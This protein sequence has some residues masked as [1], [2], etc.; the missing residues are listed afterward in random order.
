MRVWRD[1]AAFPLPFLVHIVSHSYVL[2]LVR[3]VDGSKVISEAN[4]D[5]YESDSSLKPAGMQS[6]EI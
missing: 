2:V 4:K 6:G 3:V 1:A 5:K